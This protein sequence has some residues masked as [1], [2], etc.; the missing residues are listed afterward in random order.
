HHFLD[1]GMNVQEA[2]EAPRFRFYEAGK[3]HME[4]R[5]PSSVVAAL[6]R[7][8]HRPEVVATWTRN[9]GGGHGIEIDPA[10]GAYA[11]GADPRRDGIAAGF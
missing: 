9:V 8:G 10:S 11:G 6:R 5:F 1:C 3:L 2:I 4:G 7:R